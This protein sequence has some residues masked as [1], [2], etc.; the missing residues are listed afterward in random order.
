MRAG[1]LRSERAWLKWLERTKD[2][3]N[4]ARPGEETNV[5][6]DTLDQ[7]KPLEHPIDSQRVPDQ[8]RVFLGTIGSADRVLKNPILRDALRDKYGVKAIEMEGSGVADATW[9]LERGYLVVRGICDY[10]DS[11]K[12]DVWQEYAAAVAAAYARGLLGT[13]PAQEDGETTTNAKAHPASSIDQHGRNHSAADH[14]SRQL[15]PKF[16]ATAMC[17][18]TTSAA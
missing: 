8:P 17:W 14:C 4:S 6:Y 9:Q 7:T 5:L 2:L 10:C 1:E 15:T 18:A 12:N 11:K 13:L 16:T 3:P